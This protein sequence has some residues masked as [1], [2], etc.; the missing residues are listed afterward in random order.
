MAKRKRLQVPENHFTPAPRAATEAVTGF[1]DPLPPIASVAGTAAAHSALEEL[2]GEMQAAKRDGRMVLEVPL[3]QID[4]SH[5]IRDRL[6][7]DDEEMEALKSS[8]RT[9]GQQT[10][11][12]VVALD[13][14][15]Y[16]LISGYRRLMAMTA[17][18]DAQASAG[19]GY[20]T[21]K[22]LVKPLETASDGYVA[23]VEENEIR[24]NL[25]FYERARL[26]CEAVRIGVYPDTRVAT[27]TLFAPAAPAKKSKIL[28]FTR[29]HRAL[30]DVLQFP[31]AIPEKLGLRLVGDIVEDADRLRRLK[32]TLRKNPAET[33]ERERK[34]L[35]RAL[36][37][38]AAAGTPARSQIVPGIELTSARRRVVLSGPA[39]TPELIAELQAW[40]NRRGTSG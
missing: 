33:P 24:A 38:R 4:A 21:I 37:G 14:E 26:V 19:G 8:L 5:M 2:A 12:E 39:V 6:I 40:L 31:V 22:V 23:M 29:L 10:P 18:R 20:E 9:R 3:A 15:R 11:L 30:G 36:A 27:Q 28:A 35:E 16:G 1:S 34:V 25:S 7:F 17:L 13:K 32:D